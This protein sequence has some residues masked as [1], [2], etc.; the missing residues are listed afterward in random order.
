MQVILCLIFS[1]WLT[2]LFMTVSRY[3]QVSEKCLCFIPFYCWVTFHCTNIPHLYPFLYWRTL[4]LLP[5]YCKQCWNEHWDTDSFLNYGL[6]QVY[7]QKWDCWV[8][9][10]FSSKNF[11]EV[12]WL[13]QFTFPSTVKDGFLFST[14]SP[15]F[16]VCRLFWWWPFWP[17]W[18]GW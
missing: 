18:G 7:A 17:R 5:G 11:W 4:R 1:L 13:Y 8:T 6:L 9:W 14:S 3:I 2:S 10:K 16:I 12:Q 15:A